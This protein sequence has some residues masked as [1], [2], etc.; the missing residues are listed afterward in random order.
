MNGRVIECRELTCWGRPKIR[1]SV[2]DGLR[3]RKL[4][5]SQLDTLAV[6]FQGEWCF[7]IN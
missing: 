1:I 7:E 2:L 4:D 3:A 6:V 5:D